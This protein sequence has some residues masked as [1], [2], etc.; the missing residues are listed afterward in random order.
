MR[1]SV[2]AAAAVIALAPA[3]V[4]APAAVAQVQPLPQ[5]PL[6]KPPSLPTADPL[7]IT[8]IPAAQVNA[9][10]Q[11]DT[12]FVVATVGGTREVTLS[13]EV[14]GPNASRF[15]LIDPPAGTGLTSVGGQQIIV[16][17]TAPT[18]AALNPTA[19]GVRKLIRY[20]GSPQ[21][22]RTAMPGPATVTLIARDT[23]GHEQRRSFTVT[24][25]RASKA[26]NLGVV[27]AQGAAGFIV[28][29]S[30]ASPFTAVR[31]KS[32]NGEPVE[33]DD[34]DPGSEVIC[35]YGQVAY[36]CTSSVVVQPGSQLLP[37]EVRVDI[38]DIG[39]GS[40]ITLIFKNPY[41]QSQPIPVTLKNE[42]ITTD[43]TETEILPVAFGKF[44]LTSFP[45]TDATRA[46]QFAAGPASCDKVYF[47]WQD[48]SASD[49]RTG[50][51]I[52]RPISIRTVSEPASGSTMTR[53]NLP[54]Y[55]FDV[56]PGLGTTVS[57]NMKYKYYARVGECAARRR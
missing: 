9:P 47:A 29:G 21:S 49:P 22:Y 45:G 55:E 36:A 19:P 32:V 2:L 43:E 46:D 34:N 31:V 27:S 7:A 13:L 25:T 10:V 5:N 30:D 8:V 26:P 14:S 33:F 23:A 1:R 39:K 48:V 54:K 16:Q 17:P 44:S 20:D 15:R 50:S 57:W 3:A 51:P 4:T 11:T 42:M 53:T 6:V 37:R 38:P 40:A 18:A 24:F 41:G 52:L 28:V 12:D 35:K 56:A